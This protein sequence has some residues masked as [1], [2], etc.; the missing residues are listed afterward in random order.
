MKKHIIIGLIAS[1]M[2]GMTW[3]FAAK[4]FKVVDVT[5]GSEIRGVSTPAT[6]GGNAYVNYID[7]EFNLKAELSELGD[8]VGDDFYEG[9]L[10]RQSP[11]D[12]ISTGVLEKQGDVYVDEFSSSIDYSAYDFY[13]LTLEP[14]DGNPAP[15]DHIVEGNVTFKDTLDQKHSSDGNEVVIDLTGKNFE[16]SQDTIEV[17]LWDTV[18]I[19]FES[20]SGFHDWGVDEFDA[21]TKQVSPW[22]TTSVTFVADKVGSFEFYCSVWNHRDQGMLGWLIVKDKADTTMKDSKVV[23]TDSEIKD[24]KVTK[25]LT[26]S[27]KTLKDS[28]ASRLARV[29]T[30]RIT[31]D[32]LA[33]ARNTV[34]SRNYSVAT[35]ASYLEIL[36]L[37]ELVILEL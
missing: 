30:S 5:N 21:W 13:V 22:E 14:N 35:K 33:A 37:V 8:P 24:T 17:Y 16:F 12:F 7:G 6:A 23:T 36:D 20:T 31:P 1:L 32:L 10:V 26:A 27:Q 11:F 3:A 4:D 9:W 18:T 2:L 28:I 29:D 25:K 34:K 19:N 15:A